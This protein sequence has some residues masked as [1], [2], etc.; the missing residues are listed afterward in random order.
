MFRIP[1]GF[2]YEA[3]AGQGTY[4]HFVIK[5]HLMTHFGTVTQSDNFPVILRGTQI[6]QFFNSNGYVSLT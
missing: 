5:S 3:L 2:S 1:E 6:A 4:N